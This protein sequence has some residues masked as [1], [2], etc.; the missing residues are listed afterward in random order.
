MKCL[1]SLTFVVLQ[2]IYLGINRMRR[3]W[4]EKIRRIMLEVDSQDSDYV[5][6]LYPL[7]D[8][9]FSRKSLEK[10]FIALL[11]ILQGNYVVIFQS[12]N[13]EN[14]SHAP[15]PIISRTLYWRLMVSPTFMA[16]GIFRLLVSVASVGRIRKTPPIYS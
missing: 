7:H 14:D 12:L 3:K 2:V 6:M 13:L 11:A 8:S 10:I 16:V 15:S 5:L 4:H 9:S 1:N